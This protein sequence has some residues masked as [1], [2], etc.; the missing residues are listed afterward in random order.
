MHAWLFRHRERLRMILGLPAPESALAQDA[1]PCAPRT[2]R[3][4]VARRRTRRPRPGQVT[5]QGS[6]V[7]LLPM[8]R[9]R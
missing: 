1:I 3:R 4:M 5:R 9:R 2:T 6:W 7:V 8:P